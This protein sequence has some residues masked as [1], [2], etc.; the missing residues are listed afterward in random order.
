MASRP[1]HQKEFISLFNQTA[2]YHR[3]YQVFQDFCNCAMTAIHNK[4]CYCEELEQYYLKTI[5]KYEREDVDRIVQMFSYTV[6]GLAQAPC[7]FLG[8]VFMQLGLGDKALNQFFTSWGVARMMAEIQL[9]DVSARLQAQPF[10]TLY[11]PAC[12]AGCITL[13]AADV[14]REQGHDPLCSLWVSAVDIDPLAAVMAYVQL[15]LAGIPAAVTIGN[16]LHDGGSKR[17]RYTP[18]HYLG[19]WSQRLQAYQQPQAA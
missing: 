11:E 2:R 3:R 15:S 16:A 7:D 12:G 6:L 1:D 10:V 19:N 13:A 17:T 18:A 14:L 5:K 4:Y 8:S 9:Q